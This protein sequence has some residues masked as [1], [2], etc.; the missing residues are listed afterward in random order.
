MNFTYLT[1]ELESRGIF[2]LLA[3]GLQVV[4]LLIALYALHRSR[5][6]RKLRAD[7]SP[8]RAGRRTSMGT[9]GSIGDQMV[10]RA[11]ISSARAAVSTG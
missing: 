10:R 1:N 2:W 6:W 4:F 5:L 7:D 9:G 11:L 3:V 8:G